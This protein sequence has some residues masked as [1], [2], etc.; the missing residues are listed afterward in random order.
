MSKRAGRH[1]QQANDFL[2]PQAPI[3]V[4]ATDVG[5]G[6]AYNNGAASVSFA[7][8]EGSPAATSYTVTASTGQTNTGS[9]SP[10]IVSGIASNA[11]PTFTVTATNAVGTSPVSAASASVAITTVPD[12]PTGVSATSPY[13]ANY[14]TVTWNAPDAGGK[15]I[16]NYHVTGNDGTS[17]DT[18]STSINIGQG[19]GETQAYTVYATNANGNSSV[20][21]GSNTVQTFSFVPF[22]VFGFFGVFAFAPFSVFGFFGVFGFVPFSVFGFVPFSVFGFFGVFGFAPKFSVFGFR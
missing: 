4:V 7:L 19:G 15:T 5:T 21:G 1:S 3:N 11:T 12:V 8:P 9:S 2:Q 13:G 16:T 22:S 20:S 14:D 6:R 17:G 10:I 18:S